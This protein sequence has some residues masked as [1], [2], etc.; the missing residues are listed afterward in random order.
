[1]KNRRMLVIPVAAVIMLS[2]IGV[3]YAHWSDAVKVEGTVEM[4]VL[5]LAFDHVEPALCDEF[6]WD[7]THTQKLLGEFEGKE[8]GDCNAYYTEEIYEEHTDKLGFKVLNIDIL[9]AYPQYIVHTVFKLHNIGNIPIDIAYYEITGEKRDGTTLAVIYDLLWYDPDED[10]IGE[11]WEDVDKDGEVD[12]AGPDLL[13]IN[14]E[15]TNALPFQIDPCN[16]NK[17]QIDM[18]FKQD[19]EECHVYTLHV[20]IVGVQWNKWPP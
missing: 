4:G 11:L 17:A 15:I 14:L 13:V 8:V 1:M 10:W 2:I 9:N 16:T 6:H 5:T 19:A 12:T 7:P 18:E 3:A 20:K